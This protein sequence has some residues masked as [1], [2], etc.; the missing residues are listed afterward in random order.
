MPSFRGSPYIDFNTGDV[1][2]SPMDLKAKMHKPWTL[3]QKIDLFECRVEVWQ[4]GVAAAILKQIEDAKPPSI[5]SHAAY[6]LVSV[7]FTYFE[8]IGKTLNP[9][10][11]ASNTSSEDFNV[12]FCAVY[13]KF[14]PGNGIYSDTLPSPKG[15]KATKGTKG[16]KNP[17]IQAVVAFRNRIRNG[18]YHLGYTK[19]GLWLHNDA[20]KDDFQVVQEPN[21]LGPGTVDVYHMNPHTTT[22]TIIDHFP[23]FLMD[24]RDPAKVLQTKFLDFFDKYH[25]A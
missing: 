12:G 6:G 1:V 9:A 18:L 20:G 5:W 11:A 24:L 14:K 16:T 10:S 21:P 19:N 2:T 8:M 13:P 7:G 15:T 22:R 4:F 17:D 3:D 25:I 23:K